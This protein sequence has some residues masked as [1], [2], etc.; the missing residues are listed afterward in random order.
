MR[1]S[2]SPNPLRYRG[3]LNY[4]SAEFDWKKTGYDKNDKKQMVCDRL[5]LSKMKGG[6]ECEKA[7]V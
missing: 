6:A 3:F 5:W 1:N 2:S 7:G 4:S